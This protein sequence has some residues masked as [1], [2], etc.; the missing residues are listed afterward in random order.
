MYLNPH[1]GDDAAGSARPEGEPASRDDLEAWYQRLQDLGP[2]RFAPGELEE[3]QRTI[4]EADA[5][6]KEHVRRQM[7]LA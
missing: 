4:D 1:E 3:F 5:L 7:G 2:A 6:A